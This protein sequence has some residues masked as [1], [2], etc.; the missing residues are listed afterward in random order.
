MLLHAFQIALLIVCSLPARAADVRLTSFDGI[1]SRAVVDIA[2]EIKIGDAIKVQKVLEKIGERSKKEFCGL[3]PFVRVSSPGGSV[4]EAMKIGRLLKKY[5]ADLIVPLDAECLSA[6]VFLISGG[7]KRGLVDAGRVGIHRP[8]FRE[9][10]Q[11]LSVTDVSKIRSSIVSSYK[12]YFEEMDINPALVDEMLA[13]PPDEI[14][15]LSGDQLKLYRLAVDDANYE[16]S[17]TARNAAFYGLTSSDYRSR[18]ATATAACN[19]RSKE[20]TACHLS[21]LLD[22]PIREARR[23]IDLADVRC[24]HRLDPDPLTDHRKTLLCMRSV[25][26]LK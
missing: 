1:C 12:T 15:Y 4:D 8:Y 16:E 23:R 14:K 25:Y 22:I 5:S 11:G 20:Y 17:E 26:G 6:C 19:V 18:K 7:V 13:T 24:Q 9:M 21:F 2:G 3:E 10:S